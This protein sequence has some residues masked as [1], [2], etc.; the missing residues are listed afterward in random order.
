MNATAIAY[1]RLFLL[2]SP[3]LL[4]EVLSG[5]TYITK[6]FN[7]VDLFF[8]VLAYGIPVLLIWEIKIKYEL[9]TLGIFILW[10]AYGIFNE[11]IM[12]KTILESSLVPLWGF[13]W[14][15]NYFWLNLSWSV[16][17]LPWHAFFSVSFPIAIAHILFPELC[18]TSLISRRLTIVSF[19]STC[20]L[21]PILAKGWQWN[22]SIQLYVFLYGFM[23]I[24]YYMSIY[25][26]S[27]ISHNLWIKYWLRWGLS[28]VL[29]YLFQFIAAGRISLSLYIILSIILVFFFVRFFL[30]LS[31][32]EKSRFAFGGYISFWAF[33]TLASLGA[34]RIDLLIIYPI[35]IGIL[36]YFL[37]KRGVFGL[38][39]SEKVNTL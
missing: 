30:R 18:K 22:I 1:L 3:G 12:A 9:S 11:W 21:L 7:P 24:A 2:I 31:D 5:N 25:L 27:R 13:R 8:L 34:G 17:I 6:L 39:Y 14:F 26:K 38:C 33:G 19:I 29:L 16:M 28:I 4:A 10:L 36:Y 23:V 35:L 37:R 20:L 32:S 15:G